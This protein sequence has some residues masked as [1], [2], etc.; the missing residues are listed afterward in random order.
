MA[1]LEDGKL[2]SKKE[3]RLFLVREF[4][5]KINFVERERKRIFRYYVIGMACLTFLLFLILDFDSKLSGIIILSPVVVGL[6]CVQNFIDKQK[7]QY[8]PVL[9]E[10]LGNMQYHQTVINQSLIKRS[11]LQNNFVA[12]IEDDAFS[13]TYGKTTFSV[14]EMKLERVV[15][16]FLNARNIGFS[17]FFLPQE[18][19]T[20]EAYQG[21]YIAIPISRKIK[22]HTLVFHKSLFRKLKVQFDSAEIEDPEFMKKYQILTQDQI[23]ARCILTPVF[24]ER[25]K[26]MAQCFRA[27]AIDVAFFEGYALFQLETR[28]NMFEPFSIFHKI[29]DVDLFV[30]FYDE[31]ESICEMINVLQIENKEI[32]DGSI[33]G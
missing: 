19:K 7:M 31:V 10:N 29:T 6:W 18:C 1:L 14:S 9:F 4:F 8:M 27:S 16:P 21:I 32:S 25:L 26:K 5:P 13:G 22:S 17:W 28:E 11:L 15:K 20:E 3:F 30:K 24:I 2:I 23:E 33:S 12:T